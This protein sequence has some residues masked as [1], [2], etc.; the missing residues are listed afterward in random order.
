[1]NFI[2][3]ITLLTN[4][5]FKDIS[6]R[7]EYDLLYGKWINEFKYTYSKKYKKSYLYYESQY[8]TIKIAEYK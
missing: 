8:N 7:L 4:R 6:E 1:M 2:D 3:E 5:A